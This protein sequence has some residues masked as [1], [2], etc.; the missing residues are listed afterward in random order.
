MRSANEGR[1]L[2]TEFRLVS[3]DDNDFVAMADEPFGQSKA[4]A[5]RAAGD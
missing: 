4:D 1:K 3:P 2:L 5:R